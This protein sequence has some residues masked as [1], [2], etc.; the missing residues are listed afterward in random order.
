[1]LRSSCTMVVG[2][3]VLLQHPINFIAGLRIMVVLFV[4]WDDWQLDAGCHSREAL[5]LDFDRV[6]RV[7]P[8]HS[9]LPI[10]I[11]VPSR[12]RLL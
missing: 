6:L 5:N 12:V 8:D 7:Y 9:H 1:M 11:L 2:W 3:C 10:K 4:R